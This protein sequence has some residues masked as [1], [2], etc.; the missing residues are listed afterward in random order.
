MVKM[1]RAYLKG[2]LIRKHN[3]NDLKSELDRRMQ[4]KMKQQ[5][6]SESQQ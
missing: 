5:A 3:Y 1:R 4:E 6:T 2:E